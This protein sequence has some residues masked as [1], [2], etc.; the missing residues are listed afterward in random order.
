MIHLGKNTKSTIIS[1]EY[2]LTPQNSY[3][4]LVR[5][6]PNADTARNFH[7][8]IVVNGDNCGAH[9]FPYIESKKSISK[10]LTRL[11]RV[12]L[13]KTSFYCN[14]RN[15]KSDCAYRKRRTKKT[16]KTPTTLSR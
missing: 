16:H 6:S 14:H 13:V 8:V 7:N 11:Q 2:L 10:K 9:T 3:R 15:S 5:I 12:K 1:K 4:G